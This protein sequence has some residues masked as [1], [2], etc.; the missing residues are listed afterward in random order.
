MINPNCSRT[1]ERI[2]KYHIVTQLNIPN[3]KRKSEPSETKMKLSHKTFR[4]ERSAH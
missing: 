2:W 4:G 3:S 1:E